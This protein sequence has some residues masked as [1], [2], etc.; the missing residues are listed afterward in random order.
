MQGW[1]SS[2]QKFVRGIVIFWVAAM[3]IDYSNESF[4]DSQV[5]IVA[6]GGKGHQM[7]SGAR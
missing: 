4:L 3:T 1:C 6:L 7:V 5:V 2:C